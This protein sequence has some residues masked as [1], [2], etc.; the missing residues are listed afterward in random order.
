MHES[1]IISVIIL[2]ISAI[3]FFTL[4]KTIPKLNKNENNVNKPKSIKKQIRLEPQ[5]LIKSLTNCSYS[6]D[7]SEKTEERVEL[8]EGAIQ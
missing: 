5:Y 2:T 1:E 7:D 3:S 6:E 8:T 4:K